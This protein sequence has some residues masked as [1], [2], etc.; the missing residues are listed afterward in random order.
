MNYSI[1]IL[2]HIQRT[3]KDKH[4]YYA[5]LRGRLRLAGLGHVKWTGH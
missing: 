2:T 3:A 1:S 4:E 5:E